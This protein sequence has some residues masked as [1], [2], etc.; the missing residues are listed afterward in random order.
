ME[1]S[2]EEIIKSCKSQIEIHIDTLRKLGMSATEIEIELTWHIK[3]KL[4]ED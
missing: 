1:L 3:Y 4:K 2:R